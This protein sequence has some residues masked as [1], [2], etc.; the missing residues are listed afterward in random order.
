MVEDLP[1]LAEIDAIAATEGVD[2]VAVGPSDMSRA[3]GVGGTSD[4]PKLVDVVHRVAEAVQKG[5]VA[6][7]ALPM[8]H[9]TLPRNA[10]AAPGARRGLHQL[11]PLARGAHA[12]LHANSGRRGP[13]TPDMSAAGWPALVLVEG[14]PGSGKSTTA[15]W[16]AA[17]L[18][19]Q[20]RPA[21]WV[22]EGE[23]PHPVVDP[24][25]VL[26]RDWKEILGRHFAA[27][28][29]FAAAVRAED[30]VVVVES[31]FLQ[32]S[33]AAM[34]R[35]NLDGEIIRTFVARIA[36][37]IRPLDP[38]LVYFHARDPINAFR[39]ICDKRG[40]AWTLQHISGFDGS[41]WARTRGE[42]GMGGVLAYW[43][44]HAAICDAVAAGRR[45]PHADRGTR[46]RRLAVAPAPHRGVPRAD[47][48]VGR[49][50]DRARTS[51]DS[52]GPTGTRGGGRHSYRFTRASSPSKA[53]SGTATGSCP[54]APS[55]FEA[56]A[57][58]FR[59]TFEANPSGGVARFH[60]EGPDLPH[61]RLAGVYEK[62]D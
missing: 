30:T 53:C 29:R 13:R 62:V 5:G 45:A 61:T 18:E 17:E 6:R 47:G 36:D 27:W 60:L 16:L 57:W 56:E 55:L 14:M 33:V 23:V 7:L 9:A 26:L 40:M 28:S 32:R 11:R 3:L 50:R 25:P 12:P 54:R 20:G 58:P 46:G 51:R 35:R 52:S 4:H 59:L 2:I 41:A 48:S 21:R 8:N 37:I 31:A 22:Y 49:G 15:Q 38:A 1:A 42:S 10:A 34:L 43:R 44:E 39:T 24:P 19:R